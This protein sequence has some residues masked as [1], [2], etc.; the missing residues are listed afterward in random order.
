VSPR[1]APRDAAGADADR[2]QLPSRD[3][4]ALSASDG[5]DP[6]LASAAH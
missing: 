6:L 1:H 5:G 3:P 2:Q 4:A